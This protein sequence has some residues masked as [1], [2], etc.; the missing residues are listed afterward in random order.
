M[1]NYKEHPHDFRIEKAFERVFK[2]PKKVVYFELRY[3]RGALF[4]FDK[5]KNTVLKALIVS[6]HGK[7][8][9]TVIKLED[10]LQGTEDQLKLIFCPEHHELAVYAKA[11]GQEYADYFHPKFCKNSKLFALFELQDGFYGILFDSSKYKI[12]FGFEFK[13]EYAPNPFDLMSM[14]L[15]PT[16]KFNTEDG[17]VK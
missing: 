14:G 10:T 17:D 6:K 2:A 4:S 5:N 16:F 11:N 8:A 15:K 13:N 12:D 1:T 9:S 7:R 3:N